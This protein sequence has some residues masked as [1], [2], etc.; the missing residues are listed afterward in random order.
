MVCKSVCAFVNVLWLRSLIVSLSV[1]CVP[2]CFAVIVNRMSYYAERNDKRLQKTLTSSSSFSLYPFFLPCGSIYLHRGREREKEKD[3]KSDK[4]AL[5]Q[6]INNYSAR[7]IYRR[8][9]RLSDNIYLRLCD[10]NLN[11]GP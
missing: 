10:G 8:C 2:V 11:A 3:R 4:K 6:M 1:M 5:D 9:T 7:K